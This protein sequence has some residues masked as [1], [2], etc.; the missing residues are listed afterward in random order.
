MCIVDMRRR[1]TIAYRHDVRDAVVLI[2]QHLRNIPTDQAV[3]QKGQ[4]IVTLIHDLEVV[5]WRN[6]G[7]RMAL[8]KKK[9]ISF[10]EYPPETGAHLGNMLV[11]M[12]RKLGQ[13]R[14]VIWILQQLL[15]VRQ[16]SLIPEECR[17]GFILWYIP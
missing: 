11:L 17:R 1:G 15:T 12:T 13:R 9:S 8:Q 16:S 10:N 4:S 3:P 14:R 5:G 7:T 2:N 6:P